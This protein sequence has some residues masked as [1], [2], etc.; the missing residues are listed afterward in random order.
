MGG[1]TGPSRPGTAR[2][3]PF[4]LRRRNNT[5]LGLRYAIAE[6]SM[7]GDALFYGHSGIT[8]R[9]LRCVG[10]SFPRL[11]RRFLGASTTSSCT[12]C[13]IWLP[14]SEIH[15][16]IIQRCGRYVWCVLPFGYG[17]KCRTYGIRRRWHL[18]GQ[19]VLH[20]SFGVYISTGRGRQ[21]FRARM[22]HAEVEVH[23][24]L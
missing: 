1:R 19:K 15:I 21:T 24:L 3:D 20:S 7:H 6:Q 5:A 16:Y 2:H 17:A 18:C 13:S 14:G 22:M 8:A 23:L 4:T 10:R 12:L 9:G 11:V